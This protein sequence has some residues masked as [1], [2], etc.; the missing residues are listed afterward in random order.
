MNLRPSASAESEPMAE[1]SVKEMVQGA[2]Q[3]SARNIR[4]PQGCLVRS[5]MPANM[6]G[7]QIKLAR[8]RSLD[9]HYP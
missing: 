2:A 1:S 6:P 4:Q 5:R 3:K 9:R 7:N 8:G